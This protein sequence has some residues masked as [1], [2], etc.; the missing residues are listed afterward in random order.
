MALLALYSVV[1]AVWIFR[2]TDSRSKVLEMHHKGSNISAAK[3][4]KYNMQIVAKAMV[5]VWYRIIPYY[6]EGASYAVH[7]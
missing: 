3:T 5:D 4:L 7:T 2:G 1:V 6:V